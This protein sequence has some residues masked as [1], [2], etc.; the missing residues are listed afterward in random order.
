M[1]RKTWRLEN[2]FVEGW[3]KE[4]SVWCLDGSEGLE[5]AL[6]RSA[7]KINFCGDRPIGG[8]GLLDFARYSTVHIAGTHSTPM[9]VN[10]PSSK[11]FLW[12][13][14]YLTRLVIFRLSHGFVL[15]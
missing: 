14:Y 12:F 13:T 1:I 5:A 15:G 10:I 4:G 6:L 7:E 2:G 3:G 9:V 11:K 8:A